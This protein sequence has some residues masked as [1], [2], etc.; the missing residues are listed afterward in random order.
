MNV[1]MVELKTYVAV[2]ANNEEEAKKLTELNK[3][4]IFGGED[5]EYLEINVDRKINSLADLPYKGWDITYTPYNFEED[6][7]IHFENPSA[8]PY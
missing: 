5:T 7:K 8:L 6:N 2:V 1:Y 3:Y 4:T